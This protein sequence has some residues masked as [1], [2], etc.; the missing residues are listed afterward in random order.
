MTL[1]ICTSNPGKRLEIERILQIETRS[2]SLDLP[3]EQAIEPESISRE[4]ARVAYAH[5]GQAVLVDDSALM[6]DA[7]GGFPGALVTWA[8]RAGGPEILHRMI[9]AGSAATAQA[10]SVVGLGT[11]AGV[12]SF[13]GRVAGTLVPVA[14]GVGGFGYD[15][16]FVPDGQGLS[17]AEMTPERKD[18]LS[19]RA[20]ALTALRD[21]L[22]DH[23]LPPV[24][25]APR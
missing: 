16:V 22:A 3:E 13:T 8:L 1:L 4:K 11:S 25:D 18:A 12:R 19:P 14:R 2:V 9:P 6:I 10:I 23:P 17:F 21:Y 5:F 20:R 24:P 7:L 15:P